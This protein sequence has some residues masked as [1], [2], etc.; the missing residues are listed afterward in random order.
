MP[1]KFDSL[2]GPLASLLLLLSVRPTAAQEAV[3]LVEVCNTY[4]Q[5]ISVV[6]ILNHPH[7]KD[8]KLVKGWYE[9]EKKQCQSLGEVPRGPIYLFAESADRK[10]EWK[11]NDIFACLARRAME[12]TLYSDETCVSGEAKKGFFKKSAD[13]AKTSL[14]L[15]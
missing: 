15:N 12:R 10:H 9:I 2:L 7:R 8:E 11:G 14:Q 6:I 4:G 3:S 13:G 5:N 1:G